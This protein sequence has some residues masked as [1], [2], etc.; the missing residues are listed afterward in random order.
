MKPILKTTQ[1]RKVLPTV[2]A[3]I[4]SGLWTPQCNSQCITLGTI[5]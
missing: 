5:G 4:V 3:K 2:S 1:K